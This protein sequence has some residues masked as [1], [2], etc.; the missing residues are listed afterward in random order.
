LIGF[1]GSLPLENSVE[2]LLVGYVLLGGAF[3]EEGFAVGRGVFA[4]VFESGFCDLQSKDGVVHAICLWWRETC[5]GFEEQGGRGDRIF[6]FA[7]CADADFEVDKST[8]EQCGGP[9]TRVVG[10]V[11]GQFV[12]QKDIQQ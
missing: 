7:K 9:R 3:F 6:V 1:L 5:L 2:G 12:L 4:D 11:A 10:R 8:D